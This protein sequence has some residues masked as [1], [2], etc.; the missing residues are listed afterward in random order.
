MLR[1]GEDMQNLDDFL[2]INITLQHSIDAAL[3]TRQDF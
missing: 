2:D 3:V 1:E